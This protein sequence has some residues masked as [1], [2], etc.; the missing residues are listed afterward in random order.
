M[1][2]LKYVG[3]VVFDL[4]CVFLVCSPDFFMK[5]AMVVAIHHSPKPQRMEKH[6]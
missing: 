5:W 2:K 6:E 3:A 4:D 1:L